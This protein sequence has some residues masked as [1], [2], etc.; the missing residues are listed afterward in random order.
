MINCFQL[1]LSISTGAATARGG[2][3][4][5]AAR[6]TGGCSLTWARPR[7]K[8]GLAETARHAI[9]CHSTQETRVYNLLNDEADNGLSRD[10]SPQQRIPNYS[11]REGLILVE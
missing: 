8:Y 11:G 1:L 5:G 4:A 2:W 6:P 7:L 10:C 3:R 9:E